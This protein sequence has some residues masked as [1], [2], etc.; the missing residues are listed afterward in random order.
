MMVRGVLIGILVLPLAAF[1]Q[2]RPPA[3]KDY[4]SSIN[5]AWLMEEHDFV[6]LVEAMPDA[7]WSFAP[8]QGEFKGVRTFS[9][10][11][12][13]VACANLAFAKEMRH[14]MP[15]AHCDTGGPDSAK[16]KPEL[17]KYL[18]DS[19]HLLDGEIN[20]TNAGNAMESAG[21]PY[22]GPNTRL[23]IIV[24]AAWHLADH[25]GQLVEYLRMNGI[26]PPSSK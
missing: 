10:Q 23:G 7:K 6:S 11:V 15:P 13:H 26:V 16:T 19:F 5:G 1:A 24:L 21:G 3:P 17:M 4:P 9:E 25:Y 18:R 8:T 20:T 22:G 14:E 2:S 12:K